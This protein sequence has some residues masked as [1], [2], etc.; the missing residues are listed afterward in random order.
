MKNQKSPILEAAE[1]MLAKNSD[2]PRLISEEKNTDYDTFPMKPLAIKE[3]ARVIVEEIK[4][5]EMKTK[6]G[7]LIASAPGQSG[8]KKTY[9]LGRVLSVSDNLTPDILKPGDIVSFNDL[10]GNWQRLKWGD[11]H[12]ECGVIGSMDIIAKYI[13]KDLDGIA[14]NDVQPGDLHKKNNFGAESSVSHKDAKE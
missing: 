1:S 7:I 12:V 13:G 8:Q 4:P 3:F 10:G 9:P 5:V 6:S 2:I 14:T 11:A